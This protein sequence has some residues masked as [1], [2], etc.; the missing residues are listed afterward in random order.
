MIVAPLMGLA[1]DTTR[2]GGLG[3]GEFWPIGVVGVAVGLL[4]FL[5]GR[6]PTLAPLVTCR[7]CNS[8]QTVRARRSARHEGDIDSVDGT[9]PRCRITIPPQARTAARTRGPS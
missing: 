5:T 1:I 7:R 6:R 2:A 3:N 8:S 9:E 4:F